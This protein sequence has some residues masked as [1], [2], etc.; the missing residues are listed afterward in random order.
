MAQRDATSRD[1]AVAISGQSG[2]LRWLGFVPWAVLVAAMFIQWSDPG[3]IVKGL[4]NQVFDY[5]QRQYPRPYADTGVRYIDLDEESLKR[6]G[7]WPWPRTT[8]AK[9]T[10]TLRDA[11]AAVIAF[12]IVF[13]EP[14]RTSPE[15][16]AANL[17]RDAA[18]DGTR[19]QLSALPSNDAAFAEALRTSPSV[20]GF[21][22]TER[23]TGRGLKCPHRSVLPSRR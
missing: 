12:D 13:S 1:S 11:G 19:A 5:F 15:L 9:L 14:D 20:L 3:G 22:L 10:T 2:L 23:D 6:V 17:P 16:I 21:I 8:M 7:Q 4:Q 18:W